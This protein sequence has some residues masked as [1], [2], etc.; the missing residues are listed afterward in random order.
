[1][2]EPVKIPMACAEY[3]ARFERPYIGL[4][5]NDRPRVFEAVVAALLPFKFRLANT[6]IVTTGTAA[7][8]KVIFKIPERGI[9]FQFGAEEYSFGKE[10]SSWSMAGEDAQVLVAAER[11]LMEGSGASVES[12]MLTIAMHLQPLAKTR[13][14]ILAP[15]VPA[16]FKAF[17]TQRQAQT[18]GNHLKWADGDVL[19]DFSVGFANGIF[20][21]L[22]SQFKGQPPLADILAKVRS[23]EEAVFGILGVEAATNV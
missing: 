22:T 7:D 20:L 8:H 14:E 23:D 2:P 9:S 12:C 17:M 21:R 4:I 19:L 10:G 16:P 1:M 5:A 18:F 6:E 3:R 15:F 13:E 11:A